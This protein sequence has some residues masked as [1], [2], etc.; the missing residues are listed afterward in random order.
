MHYDIFHPPW[1]LAHII[2][3][4]IVSRPGKVPSGCIKCSSFLNDQERSIGCEFLRIVVVVVTMS[5]H[6]CV[7]RSAIVS[8]HMGTHKLFTEFLGGKWIMSYSFCASLL[9]LRALVG[10]TSGLSTFSSVLLISDLELAT[11]ALVASKPVWWQAKDTALA[12]KR[13]KWHEIQRKCAHPGGGAER[14]RGIRFSF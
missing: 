6:L 1:C 13:G 8:W 12:K 5:Y 9:V 3:V 11:L 4:F 14:R 7:T 10:K 2:E